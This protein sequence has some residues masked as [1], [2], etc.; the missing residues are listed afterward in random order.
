[1]NDALLNPSLRK[2][3]NR[4]ATRA[5]WKNA[6]KWVRVQT[7]GSAYLA[8]ETAIFAIVQRQ[9]A[10]YRAEGNLRAARW[11]LASVIE[12]PAA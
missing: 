10:R 6:P 11:Y 1:M 3:N 8:S 5:D 2:V 9:V 12:G 4:T 7:C